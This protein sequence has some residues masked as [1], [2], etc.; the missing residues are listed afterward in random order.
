MGLEFARDAVAGTGPR[1]WYIAGMMIESLLFSWDKNL[2]Y[3]QRLVADIPDE[4]MVFQPGPGMNHPAWVLCHLNLYHP[5]IV[6][7]IKNEPFDDP[8]GHKY[9]M[10]SKPVRDPAAYPAKGDL[11]ETFIQGHADV[12]H[13][14]RSADPTALQAPVTLE[15]WKDAMSTVNLA[16]GYLMVLHESVH[17]GQLSAW[18]RVQG[19]KSV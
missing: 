3:A 1:P 18:R 13:A 12:T 8:K 14:L 2:G 6:S 19:L 9:G 10:T 5:V 17:L 11:V 4:R 15:R 16:L 7:L